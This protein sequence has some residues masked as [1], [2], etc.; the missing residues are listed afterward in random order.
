MMFVMMFCG[1]IE[2]KDD[3]DFL[4]IVTHMNDQTQ[5]M[6]WVLGKNLTQKQLNI[7]AKLF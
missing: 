5:Q 3:I 4:V 1:W 2:P 6:Y 7:L